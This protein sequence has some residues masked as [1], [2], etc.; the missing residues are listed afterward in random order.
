[1][2]P[3]APH[4]PRAARNAAHALEGRAVAPVVSVKF[5]WAVALR[6]EIQGA[7]WLN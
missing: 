3:L 4:Q 1:M 7:G 5:R 2:A 6:S